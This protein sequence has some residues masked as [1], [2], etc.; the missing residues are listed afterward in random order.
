MLALKQ[1]IDKARRAQLARTSFQVDKSL[2]ATY[3]RKH[4]MMVPRPTFAQRGLDR[5][6]LR[7]RA[8]ELASEGLSVRKVAAATGV[9]PSQVHKWL[10]ANEASRPILMVGAGRPAGMESKA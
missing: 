8:L 9:S 10:K 4:R 7:A 5:D 3:R 1:L 6:L 2:D